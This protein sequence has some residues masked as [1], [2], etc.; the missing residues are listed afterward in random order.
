MTARFTAVL[1][2]ANTGDTIH[3]SLPLCR[4]R[5]DLDHVR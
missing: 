1:L 3:R 4:A 2:L 5:R